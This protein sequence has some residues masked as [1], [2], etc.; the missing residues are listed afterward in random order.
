MCHLFFM[1]M[2]P[3]NARKPRRRLGGPTKTQA[4][5]LTVFGTRLRTV[6]LNGDINCNDLFYNRL[7]VIDRL[8][9]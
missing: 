9:S 3:A 1:L 7:Y 2:L 8:V 5:V 4:E 6:K